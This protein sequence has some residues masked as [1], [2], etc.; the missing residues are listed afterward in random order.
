MSL[1]TLFRARKV[2]TV[3]PIKKLEE[4]PTETPVQE[5]LRLADR[6]VA[7]YGRQKVGNRCYVDD[8]RRHETAFAA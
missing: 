5:I 6:C 7:K 1:K 3:I 2:A 4:I 8:R